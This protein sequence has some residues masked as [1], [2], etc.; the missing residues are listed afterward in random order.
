MLTLVA[1]NMGDAFC[2][3]FGTTFFVVIAT[4]Q[5]AEVASNSTQRQEGI[6]G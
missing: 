3:Y 1:N 5:D 2:S 4:D 6:G